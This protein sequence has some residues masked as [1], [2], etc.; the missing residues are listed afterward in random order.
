MA[1]FVYLVAFSIVF[2]AAVRIKMLTN[3]N[4]LLL[5]RGTELISQFLTGRVGSAASSLLA[6]L[7]AM[8]W[9]LIGGKNR[10]TPLSPTRT[11]IGRDDNPPSRNSPP[12]PRLRPPHLVTEMFGARL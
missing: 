4:E 8:G 9:C 2:I 6:S 1:V 7:V 11:S 12:T 3:L 5:I 10:K